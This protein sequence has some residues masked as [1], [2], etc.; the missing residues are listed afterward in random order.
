VSLTS[1][2]QAKAPNLPGAFYFAEHPRLRMG[3]A[4]LLVYLAALFQGVRL[5]DTGVVILDGLREG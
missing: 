3:D 4:S 1:C 2:R 5:N